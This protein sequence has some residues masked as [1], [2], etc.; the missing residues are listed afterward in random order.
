M[1]KKNPEQTNP[2]QPRIDWTQIHNRLDRL[3]RSI[4]GNWQPGP[5]H[6]RNILDER[7]RSLATPL[8]EDNSARQTL[9]LIE[10]SLARERYG[11]A[12]EFV[13]EVCQLTQLTPVPCTPDFVLGIIN[14]R[15]EVISV[16]DIRKFFSLPEIGITDLNKVIILQN[17][18]MIFGVLADFIV[19]VRDVELSAIQASTN[20]SGIRAEYLQ[21]V[22]SQGM[23]VIDAKKLLTDKSIVVDEGISIS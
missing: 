9:E 13:R 10:F 8:A 19:E 7:A 17:E 15:G 21:G 5:E 3:Q 11:I 4:E 22:T 16:I 20:I 1:K 23:A 6:T 12:S 14:L 2:E 18:N